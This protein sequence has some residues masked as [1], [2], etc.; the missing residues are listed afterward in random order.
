M[1]RPLQLGDLHPTRDKPALYAWLRSHLRWH[2]QAWSEQVGLRWPEREIDARID[3]GGLLAREWDAL[4][5][6]S[7]ADDQYVAMARDGQRAV[8]VVHAHEQRERYLDVPIGVLAWIFVEPLAR[9]VGAGDLLIGAAHTWMRGRGLIGAEVFTSA[10]NDPALG[11]YHRHRYRVADHRMLRDLSDPL[12][13][14]LDG[15]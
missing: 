9:G 13:D 10:D 14:P 6:A 2:L 3:R 4:C 5:A 7:E 11:L 8:G 15:R 12:D 1:S